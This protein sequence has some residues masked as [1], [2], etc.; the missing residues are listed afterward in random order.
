LASAGGSWPLLVEFEQA[1][2]HN[3]DFESYH[4]TNPFVARRYSFGEASQV[5]ESLAQDYGK[6]QNKGCLAI[7]DNLMTLEDKDTGRVPLRSFYDAA[8]HKGMWEF[9]ENREYLRSIGALDDSIASNPRVII[10]NYLNSPS[11][12]LAAS[13]FYS[14]CCISECEDIRSKIE[15][16]VG[17]P[18]VSAAQLFAATAK[19]TGSSKTLSRL[20]QHRLKYI[21]QGRNGKVPLYGR[22]FAQW[23]HHAFPRE[24]PYPY[25]AGTQPA[26]TQE[27]WEA[28]N[29]G[30]K[31]Q[32]SKEDMRE[33]LNNSVASPNGPTVYAKWTSDE[34]LVVPPVETR[35]AFSLIGT[36]IV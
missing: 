25:L 10:P 28:K 5:V 23:L 12:C 3:Y 36:L 8:L 26:L 20:M 29:P 33:Y 6:W 19:I 24:C 15:S 27:E 22:L 16:S 21:A 4:Q 34:E 7:K 13:E 11:N 35:K 32:L 2:G 9:S 17:A 31:S 30:M 14:V 1:A 18:E